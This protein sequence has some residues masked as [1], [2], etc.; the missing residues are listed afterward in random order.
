MV[1]PPPVAERPRWISEFALR[2]MSDPARVR[3]W[4]K[5]GFQ[6]GIEGLMRRP[7]VARAA[8]LLVLALDRERGQVFDGP[9]LHNGWEWDGE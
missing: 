8:R 9:H 1:E 4:A 2:L 5:S 7:V 3:A 6:D